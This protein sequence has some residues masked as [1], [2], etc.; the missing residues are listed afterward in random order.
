MD[1]VCRIL[2]TYNS[3]DEHL[4]GELRILVAEEAR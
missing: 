4:R 3:L 1:P 2:P